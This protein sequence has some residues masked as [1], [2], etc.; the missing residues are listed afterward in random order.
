MS[1]NL[2]QRL[3]ISAVIVSMI[4]VVVYLS[5]KPAYQLAF[6]CILAFIV[7]C[8][9]WEYYVIAR[10]KG[11]NPLVKTGIA[12][13]AVYICL[14]YV[15]LIVPQA[16]LLPSISLALAFLFGFIY[17]FFQ[18]KN[19]LV[20]LAIT[21]FGVVYLVIPLSCL[22]SINYFFYPAGNQDGRWWLVY[23]L[24]VT[25]MTDA[26]AYTFGKI[27]GK[28]KLAAHI[29]PGKTVEGAIGG[30][31][32]ALATSYSF[33]YIV[34]S[35]SPGAMHLSLWQGLVLG[36]LIGFF[37]QVGDLGESLLKRDAGV[38][39]SN[40]LPGLGGILDI[41]DSLIFT[42]PVVYFFLL[43][44]KHFNPLGSS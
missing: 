14:S 12:T 9:L 22:L 11:F 42:T 25:K 26:G 6:T 10:A 8:A 24:T 31:L 20:N 3:S 37:G 35:L 29:S 23:L 19:P 38:K 28:T 18:E 27:Y 7:G 41:V 34:Q 21:A 39:D 1:K 33:P 13:G 32:T 30:L 40:Q 2:K 17:F 44:Q 15:S 36:L 16:A 43:I 4:L 5:Y